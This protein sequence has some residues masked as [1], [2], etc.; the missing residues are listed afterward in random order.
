MSATTAAVSR[1]GPLG[2]DL[3]AT[4]AAGPAPF[5]ALGPA[6]QSVRVDTERGSHLYRPGGL[7]PYQLHRGQTPAYL[8]IDIPGQS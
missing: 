8:V 3:A 4:S 5:S 2:P 7:D 1:D 6:P